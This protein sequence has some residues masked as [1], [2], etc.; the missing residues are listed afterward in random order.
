VKPV[1]DSMRHRREKDAGDEDDSQAAVKSTGPIPP[2]S[3]DAF[4]NASSQLTP[5]KAW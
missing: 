1:E 4:R 3:I 5:S 2:K